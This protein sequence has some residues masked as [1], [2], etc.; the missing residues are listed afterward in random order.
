MSEMKSLTLNGKTYDSFVDPVARELS[1]ALAIVGSASGENIVVSDASNYRLMGLSIYGKTVQNVTPTVDAPVGLI[2][3]VYDGS[4]SVYVDG[5]Q[6]QEVAVSVPNGMRGIR[7][8]S[9]GDYTD[10]N[11]QQWISD[12]IDFERGVF[13]QRIYRKV[14]TGD[15]DF[16]KSGQPG[17]YYLWKDTMAAPNDGNLLTGA[18]CTRL[19]EKV[20]DRL[21]DTIGDGFAISTAA[22]FCVHFRMESISTVEALKEKLREWSNDKNPLSMVFKL[23]TPVETPL[24]DEELVAYAELRT[25]RNSTTVSNDAG[26]Y[27]ELDYV[28]DA[29]K[30]IDSLVV[31]GSSTAIHEATVE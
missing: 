6:R 22:P 9:G 25:H 1:E 17:N 28:M 31:G 24:S 29:K 10:S 2:S 4:I 13:V 16:A 7:V 26:A 23:A 19:V 11:G 5:E 27:M 15:E 20:P 14:F 3:S 8:S 12:E 30:Y 18:L 21:W